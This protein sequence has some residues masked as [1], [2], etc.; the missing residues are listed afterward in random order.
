[1]TPTL[2]AQPIGHTT[3]A[4]WLWVVAVVALLV[5]VSASLVA[6][7]APSAR[8][9]PFSWLERASSSLQRLT[10]LPGW[11]AGGV[12]L[13][14][15][16]LLSAGLGFF[17][18]VAW[19]IDLG[20]DTQLFTP[21]H[22]LILLGLF[23]LGAAGVLSITLATLDRAPTAWSLGRLRV[24]RGAAGLVAIGVG[25]VVGFPLDDLWHANYGVDVTMWGPTHL[26]M[27]G[28]AVLSPIAIWLL[29]GE[30]GHAA[31][32]PRWRRGLW[33]GAGV[34]LLVAFSAMQLEFDDGVPQWQ[35]LYQPVLIGLC[36]T[37]PMVA[38]R[39]ALGPW[40]AVRVTVGFL[41]VRGL[42]ALIVGP[43]LGHVV[44]HFPLYLGIALCVEAG[45]AL[46]ARSGAPTSALTAGGLA[47]TLGLATEWGFSHL[48]GR[49][50]WQPVMLHGIW[51][52]ALA[53]VAGAVLGAA[54]A[55]A[56]FWRRP[57]IPARAAALAGV[58][59]VACLVVPF[60]RQS[61]PVTATVRTTQ[62]GPARPAIDRF[63]GA[64]ILRTVD[65][66]VDVTPADTIRGNDFFW[67]KA[68]QGEG[69]VTAPLVEVSPGHW[70]AQSPV[71]TGGTWKT[72]LL[73]ARGSLV[74][75]APVVMPADPEYG[76]PAITLQ[77]QRTEPMVPASRVLMREAHGGAAWPALLAYS[78]LGL[79]TAA[80]IAVLVAGAV[81]LV[82]S[83]GPPGRPAPTTRRRS[84]AGTAAA[85]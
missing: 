15:W 67:V 45:Y 26:L 61:A 33:F 29:L 18:D 22:T 62:V 32:R 75:A 58:A 77:A 16:A 13:H 55:G 27:I 44:P 48:W 31:G 37:L 39:V 57:V 78:A 79:V 46:T 69:S 59:A 9:W 49:E 80:W 65:V 1:M 76:Q 34:G 14:S 53:A 10:G 63:G 41:V 2:T 28:S 73:F 70:R 47:G 84:L 83:G 25:G 21:A 60:P 4:E 8:S 17:W 5:A 68:W 74:M 51:A 72:I 56:A 40:A 23:G 36:A 20:R 52:A 43:V 19:H 81:S 30:A 85:S 82:R 24:P 35:A 12:L 38:A 50:P 6:S 7:G 42:V 64:S 66:A 54:L 11:C 3:P 71:P